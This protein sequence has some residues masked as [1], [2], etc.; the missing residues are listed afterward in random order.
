M[1]TGVLPNWKTATFFTYFIPSENTLAV[2][3]LVQQVKG[4]YPDINATTALHQSDL[5]AAFT[6][7][8][9]QQFSGLLGTCLAPPHLRKGNLKAWRVS[10]VPRPRCCVCFCCGMPVMFAAP[11]LSCYVCAAHTLIVTHTHS[12][13]HTD[14]NTG[15][16]TLL[17]AATVCRRRGKGSQ[18]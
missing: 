9:P 13:V 16:T 17:I 2:E 8:L 4:I 15:I 1:P 6:T 7:V 3:W 11:L 18:V 5:G 12:H 14:N 10:C